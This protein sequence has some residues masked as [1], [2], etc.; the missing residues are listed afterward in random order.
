VKRTQKPLLKFTHGNKAAPFSFIAARGSHGAKEVAPP[1][2]TTGTGDNLVFSVPSP[3]CPPAL[4]PHA[5]R[6]K[7]P[8]KPNEWTRPAINSIALDNPPPTRTGLEWSVA[9]PSPSSPLELSPHAHSVPFSS[10]ASAWKP[11][12]ENETT[13]AVSAD[14]GCG[15]PLPRLEQRIVRDN[16]DLKRSAWVGIFYFWQ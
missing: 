3:S 8:R 6:L 2:P 9:V 16:V 5:K 10:K 11:P 14:T 4:S 15:I 12:V 7:S 1:K 13:G